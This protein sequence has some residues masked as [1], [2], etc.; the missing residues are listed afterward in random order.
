MKNMLSKPPPKKSNFVSYLIRNENFEINSNEREYE[1][2]WRQ[3][4]SKNEKLV[5][6][7]YTAVEN[8]RKNLITV[9][10]YYYQSL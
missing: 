9:S 8:V 6:K 4:W 1:K 7:R 10:K 3:D 2:D 5:L